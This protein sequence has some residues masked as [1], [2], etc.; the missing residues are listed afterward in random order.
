MRTY[1]FNRYVTLK[2]LQENFPKLYEVQTERIRIE[3]DLYDL[4]QKFGPANA[5]QKGVL[6]AEM[7]ADLVQLF[8]NTQRD[9]QV[10]IERF[11]EWCARA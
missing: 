6:R 5:V 8:D 7:R 3:D 1:I 11:T 9:R 2:K 10:R 4:H